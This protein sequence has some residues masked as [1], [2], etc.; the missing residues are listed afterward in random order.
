MSYETTVL[1]T[2]CDLPGS[3]AEDAL[4]AAGLVARQVEQT[5]PG[6]RSADKSSTVQSGADAIIAA[7][8]GV[9]A[10]IVQWAKIT[11]QILDALPDLKFI[12]RLGIGYDMIDVEAATQRGI[13]V[14][15]TPSYCL[16]EV[17]SHSIA[18]IMTLARGL[19][20]Y[21]GA[22]R[23]GDWAA[24]RARPMAVRPSC[25]TIG[26]IGFGRIGSLV[27][28]HCAALGFRVLVADPFVSAERI[29][30]AGFA[31]GTREQ[32][33][34]VS[35]IVTLHVPLTDDTRHMIDA[36]ALAGMKPGSAI[37]NT[38]RGA[39]IDEDALA[40]STQR[41]HTGGAA[42]DVFAVEPLPQSSALREVPGILLS[43]HAAWYSPEALIDLP[44]HA[45]QNVID[46]FADG[47]ASSIVN[48]GYRENASRRMASVG[49]EGEVLR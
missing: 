17:A 18:M 14:A 10:L 44:K 26:V 34:A 29:E 37:V 33:I 9:Q 40:E 20:G 23:A 48:P 43:P 13:A 42:I 6:K 22:V 12:S 31:A 36:S 45:A 30:A 39:L 38:C 32:V 11:P 1:I 27:A 5:G 24:T 47:Q 4:A 35:D 28:R 2:D 41:G 7:G 25:T 15:N 3:G 46:F 8:Q 16:E 21:D 49:S 19:T